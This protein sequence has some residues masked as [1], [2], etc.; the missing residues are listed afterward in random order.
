[1]EQ[2]NL[3]GT[4]MMELPSFDFNMVEIEDEAKETSMELT[5]GIET[6]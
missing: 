2:D 3:L 6:Y 5:S 4:P 1:M